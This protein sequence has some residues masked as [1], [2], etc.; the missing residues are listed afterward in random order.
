MGDI[1]KMVN[2]QRNFFSYKLQN[3]H[4]E[5]F[6]ESIRQYKMELIAGTQRK[7]AHEGEGVPMYLPVLG[8][9]FMVPSKKKHHVEIKW[10]L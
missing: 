6:P 8:L 2:Q 9:C 1:Q 3:V 4:K 5:K 7:L 10:K